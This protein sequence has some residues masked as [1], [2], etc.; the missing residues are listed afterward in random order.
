MTGKVDKVF[1]VGMMGVGKTTAGRLLAE[2]LRWPQVDSDDEVVRVTGKPFPELWEQAGEAGFRSVEADVVS[3]LAARPG[4]AVIALGGGAVLDPRNRDAIKRAGLVVWLRAD[5]ST[6]TKRVGDG[7]GRPLL[8]SGPAQA[9]KHLS[10]T[11]AP[12][13]QNVADLVFDVDRMNPRE[14]A[15]RIATAVRGRQ[16]AS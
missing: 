6:L 16:C 11:R 9:L 15:N 10:E 1:L 5:P 2:I 12:I 7:R 13:Y 8:K 14:V 3:E 4:N